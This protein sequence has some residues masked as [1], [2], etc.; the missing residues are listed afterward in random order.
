MELLFTEDIFSEEISELLGFVDSDFSFKSMKQDLRSSTREVIK[1]IGKPIYESVVTA[2][3][4]EEPDEDE[5]ELILQVQYPI[6]LN[7]YRMFAPTNDL[8][9]SDNGRLMRVSE[10]EKQPFPWMIEL[11]NKNQEKKYYRALDEM[12][13][14]LNDTGGEAW[15]TSEASKKLNSLFINTTED[16]ED[17]FPIESRLLLIKLMPGIR[18]AERDHILPIIGDTRFTEFKTKI[19]AQDPITEDKDLFKLI[20]EACVYYSLGWGMSRLTVNLFPEGVLQQYVSE[21]LSVNATK[22]PE[23]LQAQKAKEE[24]D[25]DAIKIFGDIEREITKREL[26]ELPEQPEPIKEITLS[27]DFDCDDNFVSS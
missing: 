12:L 16:F 18:K 13:E 14:Y 23:F 25:K 9:H 3:K 22:T 17:I 5:L 6:A 27:D 20:K 8:Q 24:F 10:N 26:E 21:R 11:D 4:K 1:L 2:Y 19:K 7:A 15:K